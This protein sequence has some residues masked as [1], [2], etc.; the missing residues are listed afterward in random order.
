MTDR[1]FSS[2]QSCRFWNGMAI[3]SLLAFFGIYFTRENFY[4]RK[5]EESD[6]EKRKSDCVREVV[7]L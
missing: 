7:V 1:H 3:L 5:K 2:L 6:A 4:T